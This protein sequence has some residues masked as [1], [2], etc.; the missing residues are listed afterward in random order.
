MPSASGSG[1]EGLADAIMS[2]DVPHEHAAHRGPRQDIRRSAKLLRTVLSSPSLIAT[3]PTI[4][5]G[6]MALPAVGADWMH[7][8]YGGPP[9]RP[10]YSQG[11]TAVA[12]TAAAAAGRARKVFAGD[13]GVRE[14]RAGALPARPMASGRPATASGGVGLPRGLK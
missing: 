5:S 4:P 10:M 3:A 11:G 14:W 12:V 9:K 1:L 8:G 6:A 7:S 2:E 13:R